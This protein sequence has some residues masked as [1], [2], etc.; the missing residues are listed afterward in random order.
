MLRRQDAHLVHN[1]AVN[2]AE[3]LDGAF[4]DV[5]LCSKSGGKIMNRGAW[6]EALAGVEPRTRVDRDWSFD[7]A[8][9]DALEIAQENCTVAS[10][11]G[12]TKT[13]KPRVPPVVLLVPLAPP[14]LASA[15]SFVAPTPGDGMVVVVVVVV[16]V[17]EDGHLKK[18]YKKMTG[19]MAE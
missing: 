18:K 17:S 10:N 1:K 11:A 15:N 9:W 6:R 13:A 16:C 4:L 7:V 12:K 14:G 5:L 19:L 3:K 2:P 8:E